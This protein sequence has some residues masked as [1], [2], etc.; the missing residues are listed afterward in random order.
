MTTSRAKTQV[1]FLCTKEGIRARGN[2]CR[3]LI[4]IR[5]GTLY[6]F[7]NF[8]LGLTHIFKVD[9]V[10]GRCVCFS[11]CVLIIIANEIYVTTIVYFKLY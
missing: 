8:T 2:S 5:K 9:T 10:M 1:F 11:K 6:F 4:S 3:C 7:N